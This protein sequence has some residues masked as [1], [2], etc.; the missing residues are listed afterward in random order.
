M[1][2]TGWA[3]AAVL[4]VGSPVLAGPYDPA[5]RFLTHRTPHFQIHYHQNEEALAAR[6][7]SIAEATHVRLSSAWALPATRRT[8]VVLVDQSDLSNGSATVVPWNAIVIYPVP[9]SG[10][11]TIGNTDDWLEYVFTHEYAHI[12]HLDRSNGWARLARALFGRSAIAFPNLTLPNWQIEGLATLTESEDG[13]GRLHAGDF[14][15]VVDTAARAQRLEPLDRVNG[16]LVAWPS[17]QG[18]YAYGARFHQYLARTYGPEQLQALSEETA[19]RLPFV[20]AG[21]F[22]TVYRKSLG[23]LWKDFQADASARAGPAQDSS[24]NAL[25]RLGFLVGGLR[26]APDGAI[27]YTATDAHRFPGVYR[28]T[29]GATAADRVVTRYGGEHVSI[30]ARDL[31]FDQLELVRGAAL[32]SDLYLHEFS[33]GRTRRLT[34]ESRL[35]EGDRSSDGARIVAVQATA[36]A[37]HLVVLDATALLASPG[38]APARTLPILARDARADVVYATPRWSP[39]GRTIAAERRVR[40]GASTL[41]LLDGVTLRELASIAAQRG[42]RAVTPAFSPDGTTLL[43]AASEGDGPFHLHAVDLGP[44]GRVTATRSVLAPPGGAKS[45]LITRDGRL[46]Y[47]G[48]TTKGYDLFEVAPGLWQRDRAPEEPEEPQE[49][50]APREPEAPEA[51]EEPGAPY[52]PISTFLPRAWLP[53]IEQRDDRVLV[54]AAVEAVDVLARHVASANAAWPVTTGSVAANLAPRARPDW[55]AAYTYQRWQ[56]AFY[57]AAQDRT[58]LFDAVTSSGSRVPVAQREQTVDVGVSRPFRRVRWVQTALAAYHAEQLTTDTPASRDARTRA[59]LRTA[60]TFTSARRYGYSISLEDGVTMAVT[61]EFI[62]PG[63]GADGSAEGLTADVRAYLPLGLPHAVLAA[64]AAVAVSGGDS[65]VQRRYRLGGSDGNPSAGAFGSDAISLLRGFQDDVF[66]GDRV[67]LVNLEARV[68]LLSVQRGWGTWPIF[69]RTIHAA[70][71]ADVGHAWTGTATWGDRK[72]GYG[73]ELAA[74]VVAGFG[75]PLTLSAGIG[76]GRDGAGTIPDAREVYFR[77]GRSF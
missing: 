9:P 26:E 12:L 56:P 55:E 54:G 60:W 23:Q 24:A 71:F 36:G 49:P 17:G 70:A 39:D 38:P 74:D 1:N 42:G 33:T 21:A 52:R 47:V 61:G 4:I 43:F 2:A 67:A 58:S 73:L 77:V 62:R 10:A 32:V 15:E 35:L 40:G 34:R 41:V 63:V 68:P 22:R 5:L 57:V 66:V 37:R 59:G 27:Y 48:Y 44:G 69:L 46:I 30:T 50:E 53:I 76:W 25:T 31:L 7:A 18:W 11:D 29:P 19:G 28:I 6:L 16:G 75:L 20:T 65:D 45:P 3:L 14:R 8:H 64:R 13:A 72:I 51:P